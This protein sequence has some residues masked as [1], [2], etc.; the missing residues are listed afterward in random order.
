MTSAGGIRKECLN[1]LSVES[2]GTSRGTQEQYGNMKK[3]VG[4]GFFISPSIF[5]KEVIRRK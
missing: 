3:F 5:K 1:M 4:G 2:T